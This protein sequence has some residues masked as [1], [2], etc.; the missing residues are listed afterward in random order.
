MNTTEL[1]EQLRNTRSVSKRKMLDAAADTI[2]LLESKL[3]LARAERDAVTKRMIELETDR[4][5]ILRDLK[6]R[7]LDCSFCLHNKL[8]TP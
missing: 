2:E 3:A 8:G 6:R 4:V 7:D 1:I 5:T